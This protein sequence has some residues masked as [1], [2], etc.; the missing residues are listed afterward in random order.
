[1]CAVYGN[2][3]AVMQMETMEHVLLICPEYIDERKRIFGTV[4]A[5]D[6]DVEFGDSESSDVGDYSRV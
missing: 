5:V 3:C 1:M 2:M 4:K 6:K